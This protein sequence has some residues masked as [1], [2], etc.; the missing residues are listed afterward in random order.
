MAPG[1]GHA[2]GGCHTVS[3]I[4]FAPSKIERFV[5]MG[6]LVAA[7]ALVVLCP[8]QTILLGALTWGI[9]LIG[10]L[11]RHAAVAVPLFALLAIPADHMAGLSGPAH[12]FFV[13]GA[14]SALIA[15]AGLRLGLR[16]P[17]RADWD[18]HVLILVLCGA[19]LL[20]A[21]AGELRGVLFWIGAGLFLWWLRTEERENGD[22]H[23]QAADAILAAGAFGGMLAILA[24]VHVLDI[25]R[26]LPGYEP[27]ELEF[28]YQA[29]TRAPGLS[30]HPLRFGSLT[31]LAAI[32][33]MPWAFE[34]GLSNQ[35]RVGYIGALGLSLGGLVLSGAR[36]SWLGMAVA[37]LVFALI[38]AS[39][40]SSRTVLRIALY[41]AVA[42]LLLWATGLWRLIESRLVGAAS[43]PG[44]INQRRL[45][46]EGIRYVWSQVPPFG[47]G[48]GGAA[49]M[50]MRMGLKLLN[51]ENEYLRFFF[52][53]GFAGPVCLL[54]LGF[55]R[56]GAALR[57]HPSSPIR[58]A[59]VCALSAVLVNVGT[60][61]M[62]SWS[63]GPPLLAMLAFLVLPLPQTDRVPA[64]QAGAVQ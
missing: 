52:T 13:F 39:T 49:E 36:G 41:G 46:T 5:A 23:S 22:V 44:S 58:V 32:F 60:Y 40:G 37:V 62:F 3:T 50:A 47:V 51:L 57:T 34:E 56:I 24:H 33:A 17:S 29:G 45:V 63:M 54:L 1:S 53:A 4:A 11:P 48:F 12:G 42:G 64:E 43:H 35:R 19:T 2:S 20:H 15:A 8:T 27:N 6:A 30:G 26:L 38:R 10:F 25:T 28:T 9:T 16:A 31:M 59:A 14:T 18:F 21:A 7:G 55:R 61:N